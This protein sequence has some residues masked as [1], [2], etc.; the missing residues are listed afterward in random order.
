MT[1]TFNEERVERT[2]PLQ[3]WINANLPS[4]RGSAGGA[5][6]EQAIFV[7]SRLHP[8]LA[9]SYHERQTKPVL[10]VSE[11]TSKSVR[12]PVYLI[13]AQGVRMHMRCNFY[14][15]KVSVAADAAVGDRFFTL[16]NRSDQIESVYCEG[17]KDEW[18]YGPYVESHSRFTVS[19]PTH[20]T[21]WTF[22][23]LLAHALGIR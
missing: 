13:E 4:T 15:W 8:V 16:F 7:R 1:A 3:E 11:H 22:C 12:L 18:V 9:P 17:F 10:V 14:D 5:A 21:M 2:V 20:D 23:F 6:V 19:L